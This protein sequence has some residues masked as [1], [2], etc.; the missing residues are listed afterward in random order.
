MKQPKEN[1]RLKYARE[2][3]EETRELCPGK[4]DPRRP[5][6]IIAMALFDLQHE[7]AD[8]ATATYMA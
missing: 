3:L 2:L 1:Q 6:L 4:N 5:A 7:L 8:I